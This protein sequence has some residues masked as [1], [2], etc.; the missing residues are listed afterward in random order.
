M[1]VAREKKKLHAHGLAISE[2][3]S[4]PYSTSMAEI[5]ARN[6]NNI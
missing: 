2:S 5:P 3:K 1:L 4:L 6:E